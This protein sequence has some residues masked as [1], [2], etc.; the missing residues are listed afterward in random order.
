MSNSKGVMKHLNFSDLDLT[1]QGH[2]RSK[3]AM[4]KE[5]PY[6]YELVF[7]FNSNYGSILNYKGTIG[8]INI[9]DLDLT[10]LGHPRSKVM[11]PN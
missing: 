3:V 6:I 5:R 4:P 11:V 8:H 9:S 2:P 1:S 10:F 7:M